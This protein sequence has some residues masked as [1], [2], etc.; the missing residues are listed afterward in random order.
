MPLPPN[1]DADQRTALSELFS[2]ARLITGLNREQHHN[3]TSERILDMVMDRIRNL[4]GGDR[5]SEPWSLSDDSLFKLIEEFSSYL[6]P[7]T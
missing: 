3:A 7:K 5:G 1:L 6:K 2:I 4:I